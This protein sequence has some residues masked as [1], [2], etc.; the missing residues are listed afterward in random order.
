[1]M[2][3]GSAWIQKGY[4]I[5]KYDV[6]PNWEH[7][8]TINDGNLQGVPVEVNYVDP[9]RAR[10]RQ[11]RLYYALL[12]D[13]INWSG[14][15]K[16]YLDEYFHNLY[17]EKTCGQ[18]I[19]LSNNTTNT[20]S[21]AKRMID[22]VID[23]I[24]DNEV[25]V[26]QGYELLPRNEEHFQYQSLMHKSCLICGQHADFHHVDSVGMG[27]DRTKVDHTKHRVMALCR[28]HHTEYHK[29]GTSEFCKKYHLTAPGIKLS[30]EDLKKLEIK[31]NYGEGG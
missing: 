6:E 17:W 31:G 7:I 20:V 21:D 24:F 15:D 3:T 4:G 25:P 8:A 9:R 10:P 27:R 11:R 18:E 23:F 26:K 30:E 12:G 16:D 5:I 19:S 1:M 14:E 22:Y 2:E 13:I 29:I 28:V